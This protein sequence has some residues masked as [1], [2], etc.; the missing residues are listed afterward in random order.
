MGNMNDWSFKDP[1][2]EKKQSKGKCYPVKKKKKKKLT[3]KQR[4]KQ[5]YDTKGN[6]FYKSPEWLRLRYRVIKRYGGEC[7]AC[8]RSKKHEGVT[9]HVDHIKPRS[10]FPHLSLVFDNLQI[11]CSDCNLGKSNIDETDWRPIECETELEILN[12]AIKHI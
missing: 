1:D 8:G 9:I 11:L 10:K 12:E 5:L 7:M 6:D 3:R 2:K 4:A